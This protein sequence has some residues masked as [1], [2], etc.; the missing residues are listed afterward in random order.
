MTSVLASYA[1]GL[2]GLAVVLVLWLA[3]QRAWSR[4]FPESSDD[5][6]P[7]AGRLGCHGCDRGCGEGNDCERHRRDADAAEEER[8]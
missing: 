2:L 7:L 4:I 5:P 6:D 8:A 1:V 3:V